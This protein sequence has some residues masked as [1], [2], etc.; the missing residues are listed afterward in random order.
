MSILILTWQLKIPF[1]S[2][3]FRT[4][5]TETRQSSQAFQ[6]F[7]NKTWNCILSCQNQLPV[8]HSSCGQPLVFQKQVHR[9]KDKAKKLKGQVLQKENSSWSLQKISRSFGSWVQLTIYKGNAVN[10]WCSICR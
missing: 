2:V 4:L 6:H 7:L 1:L 9:E 8:L 3:M 5:R 10:T